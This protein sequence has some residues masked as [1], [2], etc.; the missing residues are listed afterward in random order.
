MNTPDK[1]EVSGAAAIIL[2]AGREPPGPDGRLPLPRCLLTDPFGQRVLDWILSALRHAGSVRIT[3]VAG[4]RIEEIGERYPDLTSIYNPNWDAHG[5]LTSLYHARDE[6]R[7]PLL[8][9]YADVVYRPDTCRRILEHTGAPI[10]IAVDSNWNRHSTDRTEAEQVRKNL[11]VLSGTHVQ[12]IGFLKP[13]ESVSAE[14][15]GLVAF[16]HEAVS[17]L[18][19]F[20][21][22]QYADFIDRPFG[23]AR[24]VREGFMT[25][26]LR[27]FLDKGLAIEAV[28]IGATWA[29]M[30]QPESLTRFVLGTKGETLDRLAPLMKKG[31]FCKQLVYTVRDW[32][33]DRESVLRSIRESLAARTIVVRSSALIEDSWQ[34]S[35]AGA[36]TSVLNVDSRDEDAVAEAIE[37]VIRSYAKSGAKP[38]DRNQFLVQHMVQNTV[39]SGVVLTRDMEGAPYYTVNY[40]DHSSL[41]HSVTA[42][43]LSGLKTLMIRRSYDGDGLPAQIAKLLE[44]VRE[45]EHVTGCSTL[46][47]E[48]AIDGAEEVYVLQ[49]R[50]LT[51][52]PSAELRSGE[53]DE[54]EQGALR[55]FLAKRLERAPGV[56]GATT[57]LGDMPD[58]NPAEMIGTRP[59]PLALSLYRYAITDSAWREAR[60]RI[61]YFNPEHTPLMVCLAGHPYIDVRCSLN[62]LTPAAL[63]PDLFEKLIDHYIRRLRANPDAHDKIEFDVAFTCMDFTYDTRA[64]R[65]MADGFTPGE[66]AQLRAALVQLTDRVLSGVVE[67]MPALSSAVEELERRRAAAEAQAREAEA[68]PDLV[69]H[70]MNDCIR[71]GT[72]PF[73]IFARYGFIAASLLRSL[74]ERGV[75]APEEEQQFLGTVDTVA[76]QLVRD[77]D[78]VHTGRMPLDRF[79]SRHGHLRPG[80]YE[81]TSYRYDEKPDAYFPQ[82]RDA[83]TGTTEAA[84]PPAFALAD[85]QRRDIQRLLDE[86]G[87]SCTPEGLLEFM[88]TATAKREWAKHCFTRTISLVLV[89]LSRMAEAHGL[90]RDDM[91]YIPLHA[92]LD[93]RFDVVPGQLNERL[94]RLAA[95]GREWFSR[96]IGVKLPHLICSVRDLDIVEIAVARP[97]FVTL[98]KVTA[99][100][101]RV[102]NSPEVPPLKDRIVLIDGADP[103]FDWIFTH[104]IAGLITRYG[105]AAS[106]MTIRAAEL[107]LPA[108]IGCGQ[109]LF[110]ELCHA[111]TVELDCA[112]RR[113][114]VVV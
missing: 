64:Q 80:T 79:L 28:D 68:I 77:M 74:V 85:R 50:P 66:I 82:T 57:I 45:L 114:N 53:D 46:D 93:L 72:V 97:N 75:L 15:V 34:A 110:E 42:G 60:D 98:E 1:K 101:V 96:G 113:I 5:V 112:G 2:G 13:S 7:S 9:S 51:V 65:L 4:Y 31:R 106:H 76:A 32:L 109:T 63:E 104:G 48:F 62:N 14:F 43:T 36:F 61:G 26:L 92:I 111:K 94:R 16:R 56:R 84:T 73:S 20:L 10:T 102:S 33:T 39:M 49:A 83:G 58:W 95:A 70:L 108:A 12:D 17:A 37:K 38:D 81:I 19:N 22:E 35:L 78:A 99:D 11:V 71:L 88:R 105:G 27:H 29:E 52:V 30:D 87:L 91:S 67:P 8:V 44:V 90:T 59:R 69:A 86:A 89:L 55:A 103:G 100:T 6:I 18:E 25:D 24:N 40:D 21:D 107:G 41:T 3:F 23:Q 54:A 47:I